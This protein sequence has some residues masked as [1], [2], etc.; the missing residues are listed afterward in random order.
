METGK[1]FNSDF[2]NIYYSVV[3][4]G[5]PVVLLH[6]TPRSSDSLRHLMSYLSKSYTVIAID[7][8]GFGKSSDIPLDASIN[9][10]AREKIKLLESLELRDLSIFGLH[11][12]NKIA[13]EISVCAP[14][15]IKN[16]IVCGMTHSIILDRK[17]R[18]KAIK[19][20]IE[21]NKIAKIK[22]SEGEA[23]ER[24]RGVKSMDIIY[25]ANYKYDLSLGVS[26]VSANT[27]FIELFTPEESYFGN[28]A[29]A[30]SKL[31]KNGTCSDSMD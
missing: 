17:K 31:C 2:G 6:A 22:I 1:Y 9:L 11:T 19:E 4:K 28:Q 29:P 26:K 13:T 23:L 7:T 18:A 30:L 5:R 27:L 24:E 21:S 3:G 10:L 8:L 12:G 20:L 16:L 25:N 14:F 15:L